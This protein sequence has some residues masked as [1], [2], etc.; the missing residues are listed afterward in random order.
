ME[1][2]VILTGVG[3]Q[4]V[5]LAAQ[6]LARAAILEGRE[7]M[8]LGTYGG[9]MRG[10]NT[11]STLVV[12]DAPIESPPIVSRAWAAVLVHHQFWEPTRAKLRPGSVVVVNSSIFT[13]PL[14]R[15]AW[16]VFEVPATE[17]ATALGGRLAAA[18]VLTA[19]F[20][21]LTG[22]VGL[23]ALEAGLRASLP[24]YRRQHLELNAKALRAGFEAV[25]GTAAPAWS[26]EV[27]A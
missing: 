22:L 27:A 9:T 25:A 13:A 23:E 12:A 10:G 8:L 18:L 19:A 14:D 16:R 11:D 17:L 21:R 20:A 4:G 6:V 7:V 24:P 26:G 15:D 2:E 5:Q 1:R 3:G